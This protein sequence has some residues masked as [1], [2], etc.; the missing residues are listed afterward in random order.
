MMNKAG[1]H[2][3]SGFILMALFFWFMLMPADSI[4]GPAGAKMKAKESL[5]G[6]EEGFED[7]DPFEQM[8]AGVLKEGNVPIEDN[9]FSI[10]GFVKLEAEYAFQKE[11][12]KLFQLKPVLF[13]ETEYKI[14]Q[15]Y[16]VKASGQAF[17]DLS[18]DIEKKERNKGQN[19][20][21]E[22]SA[23]ELKDV[24]LDG[25]LG[26]N[27]SVRLGRQ[28]IAWGDSDYARITDV[29]NPRDLTHPGLIDLEDARLPVTAFRLS[30]VFNAWSFEAVTLH[31]HPGSKISGKGADFDY[32]TLLRNPGISINGKHTP[33]SGIEDTGVALKVTRTFNGGDI[34]FV[35]A[36]TFDDQPYLGY[37]GLKNGV[38]VFTP[39]YDR[40][41]TYGVSSSL[42]KGSGLFKIE[43]AFSQDKKLMRNDF[44]SQISSG[45]PKAS[46]RTTRNEN[47][48]SALAGAEYTGFSDLRLSLEA[49][50]IHTLGHHSYL[51]VEEN[52]VLTYFQATKDLLHDTLELDLFWVCLNPGQGNML[53]LSSTYDIFDGLSIQAGIVFYDSGKSISDIHPYIDQDRFF[54]RVKYSF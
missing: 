19:L 50:V 44:L 27:F 42:V 40:V 14:N 45:I 23:V 36:N 15:A 2:Q 5:A 52:E 31:E 28:I 11:N 39:E 35:A 25:K 49:Q 7:T 41:T 1:P 18:Y 8:D 34:S 33:G 24:Y 16:K 22:I 10:H 13:I 17:Y 53:R 3:M 9:F 37:D 43:T 21:D 47:Q 54:I 4:A 12:E 51:G 38:M 32:Y 26:E 48:I 6:F 46:V 30:G 20:D 29:I